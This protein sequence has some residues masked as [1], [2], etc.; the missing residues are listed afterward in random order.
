MNQTTWDELEETLDFAGL[1]GKMYSGVPLNVSR[2]GNEVA[3]QLVDAMQ[4]QD[5]DLMTEIQG[6]IPGL[7][8]AAN[9][10]QAVSNANDIMAQVVEL[11]FDIA[12]KILDNP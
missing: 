11:C 5:H 9:L 8:A 1:A 7:A 10:T 12:N 3:K 2:F 6:S 4:T